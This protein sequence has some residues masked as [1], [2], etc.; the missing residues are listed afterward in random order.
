MQSQ[1]CL[2]GGNTAGSHVKKAEFGTVPLKPMGA[3][4]QEPEEVRRSLSR[5]CTGREV[6][7]TPGF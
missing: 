1:L 4:G 7:L 6:L 5:A 3:Q 2:K